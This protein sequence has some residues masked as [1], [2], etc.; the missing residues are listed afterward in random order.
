MKLDKVKVELRQENKDTKTEKISLGISSK[1]PILPEAASNYNVSL[2]KFS[3]SF[4]APILHI[5]KEN[6]LRF[7]LYVENGHKE[8]DS[9]SVHGT[10]NSIKEFCDEFNKQTIEVF[11][12]LFPPKHKPYQLSYDETTSRLSIILTQTSLHQQDYIHLND[13]TAQFFKNGFKLEPLP[14]EDLTGG[15]CRIAI[16]DKYRKAGTHYIEAISDNNPAFYNFD[17]IQLDTSLPIKQTI[18]STNTNGKTEVSYNSTLGTVHANSSTQDSYYEGGL[19]Y[20]P[21]FVVTSA[22]T[23]D[24][25]L[26]EFTIE[27]KLYYETGFYIDLQLKGTDSG[28]NNSCYALVEFSPKE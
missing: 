10:F 27:P 19:I 23:S 25:P 20:L 22:L 11:Y 7:H 12:P 4:N 26:S 18:T 21:N 14:R 2:L 17:Y 28:S 1:T 24:I 15:T 13:R 16:D 5:P 9:F 6:P 3:T 8:G